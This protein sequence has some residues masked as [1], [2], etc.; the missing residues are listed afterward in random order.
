MSKRILFALVLILVGTGMVSAGGVKEPPPGAPTLVIATDSTWPP[1]EYVDENKEIVG[2]DIDLMRAIGGEAGFN[3]EFK[4]VAWD[5]I[6]TGLMGGKY[7]A[8]I[9]SLPSPRSGRS[10]WTSPSPTSTPAKSW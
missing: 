5:G 8:I 10:R 4:S 3:V 7:D 2:F 6:F 9:S 1:M